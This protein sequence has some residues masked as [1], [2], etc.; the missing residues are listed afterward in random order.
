MQSLGLAQYRSTLVWMIHCSHTR[1]TEAL[2]R[3]FAQYGGAIAPEK[4]RRS[5]E[6]QGI[7]KAS[8]RD[9]LPIRVSARML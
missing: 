1:V 6:R 2:L 5:L 7:I 9:R 8:W 4:V 3:E